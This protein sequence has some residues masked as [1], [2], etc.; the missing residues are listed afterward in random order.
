[1]KRRS[2][3]LGFAGMLAGWLGFGSLSRRAGSQPP[4][5]LA[6]EGTSYRWTHL[7]AVYRWEPPAWKRVRMKELK[8]GDVFTLEEEP[9]FWL[10]HT[11][12]RPYAGGSGIVMGMK[13]TPAEMAKRGLRLPSS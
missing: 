7:R 6:P 13:T 2:F 3:L 9:G 1:M 12:G 4:L 8:A 11:N 5:K 10:A